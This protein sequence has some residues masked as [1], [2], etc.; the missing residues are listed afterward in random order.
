M[1]GEVEQSG[2]QE[3]VDSPIA[4]YIA[5]T[6]LAQDVLCCLRDTDS[7]TQEALIGETLAADTHESTDHNRVRIAVR[8]KIDVLPKLVEADYIVTDGHEYSVGFL[9]PTVYD[10]LEAR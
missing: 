8:L 3:A 7:L 1:R 2:D 6:P 5:S 9:T 4:Q 10:I